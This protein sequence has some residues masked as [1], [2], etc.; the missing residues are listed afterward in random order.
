VSV[1]GVEPETLFL[2]ARNT[3]ACKEP[4]QD[5]MKVREFH[6]KCA[7]EMIVA[8]DAFIKKHDDSEE[9]E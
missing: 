7:R 8:L 3:L 5:K 9:S 2:L 6:V 4:V 1:S